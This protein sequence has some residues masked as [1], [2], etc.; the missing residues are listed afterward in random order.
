MFLPNTLQLTCLRDPTR[1][2]LHSTLKDC[3]GARATIRIPFS[4]FAWA[5]SI[6][7]ACAGA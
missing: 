3:P 1:I 7:A 5:S 2:A 6:L 4:L